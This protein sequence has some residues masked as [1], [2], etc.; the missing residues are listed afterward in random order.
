MR[1]LRYHAFSE[2]CVTTTVPK[3]MIARA[4][5]M[6]GVGGSPKAISESAAPMNGESA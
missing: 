3:A 6:S 4:I 5:Q 2:S 1:S